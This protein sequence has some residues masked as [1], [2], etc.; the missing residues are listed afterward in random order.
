M[1][2][3]K[4]PVA[5]M[6]LA[7]V[8]LLLAAVLTALIAFTPAAMYVIYLRNASLLAYDASLGVESSGVMYCLRDGAAGLCLICAAMEAMGVCGRTK[9][10]SAFSEK[11]MK[12]LGRIALEIGLAGLVTLVFGDSIVAFL[13]TGLPA[14]PP[15]VMRLLLPFVLLTASL[16]IRAVQVLMRRVLSLQ[17]DAAL[18]V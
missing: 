1:K 16:M 3:P 2:T 10:S 15:V 18:T 5:L 11:N 17:D 13:M 6:T 9:K 4:R 8:I 14:I 7:Q 12:A